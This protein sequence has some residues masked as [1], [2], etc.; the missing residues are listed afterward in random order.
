M[1]EFPAKV[2][3]A[4]Y[5]R[6]IRERPALYQINFKVV[7]WDWSREHHWSGTLC[8]SS[9]TTL[10][11]AIVHGSPPYVIVILYGHRV[12]APQCSRGDYGF[13]NYRTIF[14][15]EDSFAN[16]PEICHD[17][18]MYFKGIYYIKVWNHFTISKVEEF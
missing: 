14:I 18:I 17:K 3:V 15:P 1:Y 12:K 5:Y 7:V 6:D 4:N 16:L 8:D 13:I 11:S 10:T 9:L 2:K